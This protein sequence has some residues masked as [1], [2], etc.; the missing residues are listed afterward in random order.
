MSIEI[1]VPATTFNVSLY[2][3]A[4]RL[5]APHVNPESA[6]LEIVLNP[7]YLASVFKSETISSPVLY[8]IFPDSLTINLSLSI[9][10]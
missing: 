3:L 8:L 2:R 5:D 1:F 9:V 10:L 7:K 4:T 6:T